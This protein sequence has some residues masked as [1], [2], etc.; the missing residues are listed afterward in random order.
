MFLG[1]D[2]PPLLHCQFGQYGRLVLGLRAAGIV[3]A[4]IIT[5]FRG[6]DISRE[7]RKRGD[8]VY[9]DLFRDG[10]FFLTNCEFFKRRL[11][12]I[13]CPPD[14]LAVS[15]SGIDLDVFRPRAPRPVATSPC[16]LLTVGRLVEKKGTEFAIRAAAEL[17][18]D[19]LDIRLDVIGQGALR[20]SLERLIAELD[21]HGYITLH[22]VRRP[23]EIRDFLDEADIFMATSVTARNGDQDATVNTV[24]EAM[25]VGVPVVASD[26][27]GIPEL[28]ED[29]VTGRLVPERDVAALAV[30]ARWMIDNAAAR[31]TIV[32]A[33]RA[34]VR[35]DY[36]NRRIV[37]GLAALYRRLLDDPGPSSAATDGARILA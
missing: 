19:G 16:R 9:A 10:D 33:A 11:I 12:E 2:V 17:K 37:N 31:E 3:N 4:K 18:R 25:A 6:S 28:V 14:R 1:A 35:A 26:H 5:H 30:A 29:G 34:R 24:K 32:G 7:L 23:T 27:G 21:G 22:G 8:A 13:G 15:R 36:D 20:D